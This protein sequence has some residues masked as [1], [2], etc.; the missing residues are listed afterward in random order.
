MLEKLIEKYQDK[1]VE[2]IVYRLSYAGRYIIIKGASLLGSLTIMDDAY[3]Q[4]APDKQR[5]ST[6]L[7]RH[8]F[9]HFF[10]TE[11]TGRF[12]MK[13]LAKLNAK[14]SQY[15]LLKRE[16]MELDK[17]RYDYRCLNN[18]IDI[19]IP[20][21]NQ[22]KNAFG[23]LSVSAV[24]NFKR[25]MQSKERKDY[26]KRYVKKPRPAQTKRDLLKRLPVQSA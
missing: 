2:G 7:Y 20:K 3:K 17:A 25:W 6:H 5:F 8:W 10:L 13:T 14:T 15:Q 23:W 19:Y 4:Y 1:N 22:T 16:Q 26:L 21:W 11:D 9:Q 12:R 24:A 18:E